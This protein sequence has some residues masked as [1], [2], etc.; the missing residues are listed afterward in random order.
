[1]SLLA[2]TRGLIVGI[3]TEHSIGFACARTMRA[4]GADVAVTYR[5]ARAA[6]A[7]PL[8][9]SLDCPHFPL[10]IDDPASISATFASL[11]RTFGRL[12]FVV[13][14]LMHVPPGLLDRPLLDV[15]RTDLSRVLDVAVHSFVLLARHAHPLLTRSSSPRLVTL[16]SPCSHR[17]TPH[18]HVAGIAKAALESAV[19]YLA[20][21][22]GPAG[23]L[24]NCVSPG[25]IDTDGAVSVLSAPVAAS[26]RAHIARRAATRRPTELTDVASTVAWLSSPLAQNLTGEVITVDGAFARSYF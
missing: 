7:G 13:H 6:T 20:A 24:V 12:D 9:A 3:S 18:Y 23:I 14:T 17:M 2:N 19:L 22:L 11:D 4:L 1:V 16:S 25:L 8:A 5:P 26:S 21:E 15:S 10:D